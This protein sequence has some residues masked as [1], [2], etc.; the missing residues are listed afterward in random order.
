MLTVLIHRWPTN[1][2]LQRLPL[3]KWS[4]VNVIMWGLILACMA[5]TKDFAT[6]MTVRV[7]LG[8]FEAAVSPGFA[9]FTSQ[10]YTIREQGSRTG[11]WFR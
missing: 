7:F 9:L 1:L 4:A 5:G 10:W 8:V 11:I 6:A 2:L 3:A